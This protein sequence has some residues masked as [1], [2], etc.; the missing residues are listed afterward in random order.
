[1]STKHLAAILVVAAALLGSAC[2]G[3]S[4]SSD[5][6]TT[7]TS[8]APGRATIAK[9]DVPES[10][11]CAANTPSTTFAVTYEV[12]GAKRQQ[13]LVDGRVEPGTDAASATLAAVPVHCDAV[14]H[15]VVLV[16]YDA[17]GKRTAEKKLLK[18]ELAG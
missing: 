12:S 17:S 8:A 18:T 10:I 2:S 11:Q 13:L 7:S 3:D 16:A 15:T 5:A 1:V 9:F 4:G 6:S 14:P